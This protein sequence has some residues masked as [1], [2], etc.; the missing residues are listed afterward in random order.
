MAANSIQVEV[1]GINGKA[2]SS[3]QDFVVPAAYAKVLET[4]QDVAGALCTVVVVGGPAGNIYTNYNVTDTMA[5]VL[6]MLNLDTV[7]NLSVVGTLEVTGVATFD[8]A[9]IRKITAGAA[10]NATA[11]ATAAQVATGLIT[12]TSAAPTTITMPTGTLL[13]GELGAGRGTS[14]DLVVDNTLGAST[15]TMAVAVNGILSAAAAANG[16]SQGLLT[17]PSG[18]TGI[19]TFRLVFASATA[20]VITRIA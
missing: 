4:T 19:A 20:Y 9:I 3:A 2:L 13:G 6:A 7:S 14:F 12:S 18:V 16:A 10:I 17:V 5:E 1:V 11:T 15:V 8:A